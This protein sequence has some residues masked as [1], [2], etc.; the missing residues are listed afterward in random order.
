MISLQRKACLA[1]LSRISRWL[2]IPIDLS[3]QLT[4]GS[5]MKVVLPDTLS[6]VVA[7][8]GDFETEVTEYLKRYLKPGDIFFDVGAHFGLRSLQACDITMG[9]VKII[10][11]EPGKR[12]LD[13]LKRNLSGESQVNIVSKAVSNASGKKLS[14]TLFD[15]RFVGSSTLEEPRL[16][17]THL[18][19]ALQSSTKQV[20]STISIDDYCRANEIIPDLLKLDVENHELKVL[21]GARRILKKYHPKIILEVGDAGRTKENSTHKCL[22]LLKKYDYKFKYLNNN[23]IINYVPTEK[24]QNIVCL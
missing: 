10:S 7:Y 21:Q 17:K 8:T 6:T 13:I 23:K 9:D 19:K 2:N 12:Q 22:K 11:F 5:N 16:M 14:L 1:I 24:E 4:T 18:R 15:T 3:V 20:V